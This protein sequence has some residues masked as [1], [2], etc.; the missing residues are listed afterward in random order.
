MSAIQGIQSYVVIM[1]LYTTCIILQERHKCVCM[2][3]WMDGMLML[4]TSPLEDQLHILLNDMT[5]SVV[6]GPL[7]FNSLISPPLLKGHAQI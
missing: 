3:G 1:Y 4:S 2:D 6:D 7:H 5:Q